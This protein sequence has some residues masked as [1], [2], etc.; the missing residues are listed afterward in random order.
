MTYLRIGASTAPISIGVAI[1][2]CIIG[3]GIIKDP[4]VFRHAKTV[5]SRFSHNGLSLNACCVMISQEGG[6]ENAEAEEG[7]KRRER[8]ARR[9]RSQEINNRKAATSRL[10]SDKRFGFS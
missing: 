1:F 9:M 3:F 5:L 10:G 4:I 8:Q 7:G 2:G 6:V